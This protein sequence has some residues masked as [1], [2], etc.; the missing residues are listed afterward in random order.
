MALLTPLSVLQRPLRSPSE[1]HTTAPAPEGRPQPSRPRESPWV[2]S[3]LPELL[4]APHVPPRPGSPALAAVAAMA[5]VPGRPLLTPLR[6]AK[7]AAQENL[8]QPH[9]PAAAGAGPAARRPPIGSRGG[10][11]E[12]QGETRHCYWSARRAG[13]GDKQRA[14]PGAERTWPRPAS[15]GRRRGCRG[16]VAIVGGACD[17]TKHW[18][19]N[20]IGIGI[21]I[22]IR[23]EIGVKLGF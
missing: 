4:L 6:R 22:G 12:G 20:W 5:G 13:G 7:M 18:D 21:G 9:G 17:V 19:W 23:T 14:R 1:P 3:A 15:P 2:P 16:G 8:R 10:R 11:G